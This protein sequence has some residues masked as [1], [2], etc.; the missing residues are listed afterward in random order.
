[1]VFNISLLIELVEPVRPSMV[2]T[3]VLLLVA[4]TLAGD[5]IEFVVERLRAEVGSTTRLTDF[6]KSRKIVPTAV[7]TEAMVSQIVRSILVRD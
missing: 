2:F 7:R 1:M 4:A 6:A 5:V 3:L